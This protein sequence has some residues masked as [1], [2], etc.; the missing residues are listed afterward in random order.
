MKNLQA[1]FPWF[2]G[3]RRCADIV[4]PRLGN[5]DLYVEPFF[6]SGAMLLNRP[7]KHFHSKI[8][9]M[10]LVNDISCYLANFWRAIK[11]DPKGVSAYAVDPLNEADLHARHMWLVSKH[12]KL[13]NKI[14]ADPFWFSTRVAGWWVWG[15]SCWLGRLW[16]P[17]DC[18]T[19]VK[20]NVSKVRPHLV[21]KGNGVFTVTTDTQVLNWFTGLS[22][23]L[24]NVRVTCGDWSR[25]GK[26]S[27]WKNST[28][29]GYFLD[30][31]YSDDK[32]MAKLYATDSMTLNKEIESW[33]VG[34]SH[35]SIR[36]A[37]CGY[38]GE[39]KL[40]GWDC[41]SWIPSSGMAQGT[42]TKNRGEERIWFSP[43]CLG[44][45]QHTQGRLL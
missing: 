14:M 26:P 32:R 28:T 18:K 35:D 6:G 11:Q 31:P 29:V 20:G 22:D 23:R 43:S 21:D 44:A 4:W 1:P 38:E 33:C 40:K 36:I 7:A 12:D 41:I 45:V 24:R 10:E 5:V 9:N 42:R 34:L 19:G 8:K 15:Q 37:L 30:P 13:H 3:K 27:L 17:V 16:C 39:Y 2:G 25:I